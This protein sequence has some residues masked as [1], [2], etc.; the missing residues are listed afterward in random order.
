MAMTDDLVKMWWPNLDPRSHYILHTTCPMKEIWLST[1]FPSLL[2]LSLM[3][4]LLGLLG[5]CWFWEGLQSSLG[6]CWTTMPI[7]HVADSLLQK[8]QLKIVFPLSK[9]LLLPCLLPHTLWCSLPSSLLKTFELETASIHFSS[10][11]ASFQWQTSVSQS[12]CQSQWKP[13]QQL[14]RLGSLLLPCYW[15]HGHW[16][17]TATCVH[18]GG[19]EWRGGFLSKGREE[20]QTLKTRS[21]QLW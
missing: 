2:G 5:S 14:L 15:F 13:S 3:V 17:V 10:V 1:P 20:K 9:L 11:I 8:A 12:G 16:Q 6:Q 18:V 4:Q 21:G 7:P 19:K